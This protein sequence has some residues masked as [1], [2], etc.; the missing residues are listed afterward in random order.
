M[1][2]YSPMPPGPL[3][4]LN[5][6][7]MLFQISLL[8]FVLR[9]SWPYAVWM[10]R[11]LLLTVISGAGGRFGAQ[12]MSFGR[13]VAPTSTPQGHLRRWSPGLDFCWLWIDFGTTFSDLLT[14]CGT[15]DVFCCHVCF[16]ATFF[17]DFGVWIW[18]SGDKQIKDLVLE[19]LQ[20]ITLQIY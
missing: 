14:S 5:V 6:L 4:W 20:K 19:M 18:T 13:L 8:Q 3:V 7:R 9:H 1:L 12:S 17:N 11:A 2:R 16:Q 15:K 10:P